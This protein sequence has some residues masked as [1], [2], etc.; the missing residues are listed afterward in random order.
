MSVANGLRTDARD[1]AGAGSPEPSPVQGFAVVPF[2][3]EL[4]SICTFTLPPL[5]VPEP[6]PFE[7]RHRSAEAFELL[8]DAQGGPCFEEWLQAIGDGAPAHSY[9]AD[10]FLPRP[11]PLAAAPPPPQPAGELPDPSKPKRVKKEK[12][13][14]KKKPLGAQ[15]ACPAEATKP[16]AEA[17]RELEAECPP[18]LSPRLGKSLSEYPTDDSLQAVEPFA[19]HGLA[20]SLPYFKLGVCSV[21]QA[22]QFVFWL[23]DSLANKKADKFFCIGCIRVQIGDHKLAEI[24]SQGASGSHSMSQDFED[25]PW[26]VAL[27]YPRVAR[28]PETEEEHACLTRLLEAKLD[29]AGRLFS[30]MLT[31]VARGHESQDLQSRLL[32]VLFLSENIDAQVRL[33][34]ILRTGSLHRKLEQLHQPERAYFYREAA[35]INSFIALQAIVDRT[36]R[37]CELSDLSLFYSELKQPLAPKKP[38]TLFSFDDKQLLA[39]RDPDE[40]F[41]DFNS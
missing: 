17:A 26:M 39:K 8:L 4:E 11:A 20:G 34:Q 29:E 14:L 28:K 3:V 16:D 23:G 2:S 30:R 27:G 21:C 38:Q 7:R 1:A 10:D 13:P 33:S 31:H 12:P 40:I 32:A 35:K 6:K 9:Y 37:P 15:S 25:L 22:R 36:R 5:A 18:H 19:P 24:L 41:A